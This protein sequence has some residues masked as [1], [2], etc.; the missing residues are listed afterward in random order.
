[1]S[2]Q[3]TAPEGKETEGGE[4][5]KVEKQFQQNWDEMVAVFN[6]TDALRKVKIENDQL[7]YLVD[8]MLKE[9]QEVANQE[10]KKDMSGLLDKYVL[11]EKELADAQK[12]YEKKVITKRKE[13]I[14]AIQSALGKVRDV[15]EFAKSYRRGLTVVSK[16][17]DSLPV[18][19]LGENSESQEA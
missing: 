6:G 18:E 1:M 5:K 19:T 17:A 14:A 16:G 15:K 11:F 9:R 7:G 10:F 3:T 2:D 12:E 13:F 4:F 8:E